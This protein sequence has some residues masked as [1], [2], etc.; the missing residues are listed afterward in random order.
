MK[1]DYAILHWNRPYFADVHS[2]LCRSYFPFVDNVVLLDDGSED[3]CFDILKGKFDRVIRSTKNLNDWKKG[4]AGD[5]ILNFLES[6]SADLV[7]FAEDD[8]L[9]CPL[10]IDDSSTEN[11]MIPP[12]IVFPEKNE[13]DFSAAISL[14]LSGNNYV[15]MAK[16]NYGWKKLDVF[17]GTNN[18]MY[19]KKEKDKR[20]YSNWPWMMN[21]GFA[22]N[23]F[24]GAGGLPIWQIEAKVDESM[25]RSVH[26]VACLK[27]KQ[28]VHAGFIC[29]SR[30]DDFEKIGKF[31]FNRRRSA[32]RFM[33]K[34]ITSLDLLRNQF[35]DSYVNGSRISESCLKK[36]GLYSALN[37]FISQR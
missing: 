10:T 2:S 17:P 26:Q 9:P 23:I 16:S 37:G 12:D 20:S 19:V 29:S 6:S 13:F 14:A 7:V 34:K 21:R 31:N 5:L 32:S 22:K 24:K 8:F 27:T 33:N 15:N 30:I 1:I 11:F 3:R 36:E 28:H 35:M 25:R 4:S 18:F